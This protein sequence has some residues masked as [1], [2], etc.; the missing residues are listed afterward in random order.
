MDM[1][2]DDPGRRSSR[3]LFETAYTRSPYRYTVIGYPDVF[4]TIRREDLY[5][6]YK[7]K[8][9]PNNIF[10]VVVGDVKAEA[11]TKFSFELPGVDNCK[12]FGA[13]D[14]VEQVITSPEGGLVRCGSDQRVLDGYSTG[15]RR[16]L[17]GARRG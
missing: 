2:V 1:N 12:V 7:E 3:R 15:T 16:V 8:Y 5:S 6:Y 9:T 10:F 17:T 4:K 13:W 14:R 11:E